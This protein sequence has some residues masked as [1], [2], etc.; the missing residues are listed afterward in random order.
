[1]D[2]FTTSRDP[3]LQQSCNEF[4]AL[5]TSNV[6]LLTSVFPVDASCEDVGA[7]SGLSIAQ[8]Y[9][10]A[11][12]ARGM[13]PYSPPPDGG[14]D[15]EADEGGEASKPVFNMTPYE[16]PDTKPLQA[17]QVSLFAATRPRKRALSASSSL[18]SSHI[19]ALTPISLILR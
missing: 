5:I 7:D 4:Q 10:D 2:D 15:S 6:Q 12:L 9:V 8:A 1:M 19:F 17:Q 16:R 3:I 14:S 13:N 11:A 18:S